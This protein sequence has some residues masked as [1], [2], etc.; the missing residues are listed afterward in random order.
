MSSETYY[1]ILGVS[2]TS[3]FEEIKKA[4]RKLALTCHPDKGA[5]PESFQ[6]LQEAW[7]VL[8]D[9]T[10]RA[11]YDKI[12]LADDDVV[13]N[14]VFPFSEFSPNGS[15]SYVHPCRCG[16]V[17]EIYQKEVDEKMDLLECS[18]CSL[19]CKIEY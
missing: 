15:S 5:T 10:K 11:N 7:S 4:Y 6:K 16:G 1:S 17:F 8:S 9:E 13:V 18:Q 2:P 12:V 19:V 14:E 3:S